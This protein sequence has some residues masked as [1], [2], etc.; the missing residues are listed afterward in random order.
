MVPL[1][2]C[3]KWTERWL[4]WFY[5]LTQNTQDIILL[6]IAYLL[7]QG[8]LPLVSGKW[9]DDW[10]QYWDM[11]VMQRVFVQT[12]LGF[13]G[14]WIKKFEFLLPGNGYLIFTFSFYYIAAI[15]LYVVL[16]TV[17]GLSRE[18]RLWLVSFFAVLPIN[19]ARVMNICF[20][21][22]VAY[23]AFFL[24][25]ALLAK[26]F[27]I[28]GFFARCVVRVLSLACFFFSY[29]M[30]SLLVFS[31]V[32][33]AY[34]IY[35]EKKQ[36]KRLLYYLDFLLLPPLYWI[37]KSL[38]W[39]AIGVYASYYSVTIPRLIKSIFWSGP[40]AVM[41]VKEILRS[42]IPD[43]I[44]IL[45]FI[46]GIYKLYQ[47]YV[48]SN[49]WTTQSRKYTA[50][51]LL[52]FALIGIGQY[53]YMVIGRGFHFHVDGFVGRDVILSPLGAALV[54]YYGI[55]LFPVREAAKKFLCFLLVLMSIVVFNQRYFGYQQW[56]YQQM[57]LREH[58]R[59]NEEIQEGHNFL[60]IH[61]EN[62]SREW[63]RFWAL[64][65]IA[66]EAFGD[67]KR[68]FLRPEEVH[69]WQWKIDSEN[70]L[71]AKV[72][73]LADHDF[74][75]LELD[76]VIYYRHPDELKRVPAVLELKFYE[77]FCEQEF[78]KKLRSLGY[79]DYIPAG[80]SI[81]NDA[82]MKTMWSEEAIAEVS[83]KS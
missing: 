15:S 59:D 10:A 8:M 52:G 58:M 67:E 31:I 14:I 69:T 71:R 50:G 16:Q 63:S 77:L 35:K 9:G 65:G 30:N 38:F 41:V 75:N 40:A 36:I 4:K 61:S 45:I 66:H 72:N 70:A 80:G 62:D 78:K 74:Q 56:G 82:G 55:R 48:D 13:I 11:E 81:V 6:S 73:H 44:L 57:V 51:V 42:M 53:P 20:P 83:Q 34:I 23:G 21:Y 47:N 7:S 28:Q 33:L 32:P 29:V 49:H 18:D 2:R 3:F 64:S 5:G 60:L 24:A 54:I 17:E 37:M 46:F 68:L 27:S 19:D 76:G 25:F 22:A 39:P 43:I 12:G 26:F 79:L 1:M